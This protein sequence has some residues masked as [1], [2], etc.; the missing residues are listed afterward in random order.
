MLTI[1][2]SNWKQVR[3]SSR[4]KQT[5]GDTFMTLA[6]EKS[7]ALHSAAGRF[8]DTS[9]A[10]NM[11]R[12]NLTVGRR[13]DWRCLSPCAGRDECAASALQFL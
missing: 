8:V 4:N 11:T 7:D 13:P 3:I 5:A 2:L 6:L 12:F 9:C 10:A 1:L